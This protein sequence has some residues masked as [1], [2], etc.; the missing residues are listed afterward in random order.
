[1]IPDNKSIQKSTKR[2]PMLLKHSTYALGLGLCVGTYT[3]SA[4]NTMSYTAPEAHFRNGLEYYEKL[5]YVAA[6]QEFGDY[7]NTNDNLLSTIR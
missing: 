4:Q 7:L 2:T 1:M 5:N 6:R 3:V